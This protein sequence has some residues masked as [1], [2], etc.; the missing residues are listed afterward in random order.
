MCGICGF[1]GLEDRALLRNMNDA[2][3]HRGPDDS[4]Y[5]VDKAVG[6]GHRRLSIIDL[7]TGH[8]PLSNED[9]TIWVVFNGEIYNYKEL[10]AELSA[11]HRFAT[12]SDTEVIVHL[13]EDDPDGFV[14]RLDGMFALAIYDLERGRLTLARDPF[15]KKPLYYCQEQR[16]FFFAS[17]IKAL[18]AAGIVKEVDLDM[19]A[20]FLGYQYTRGTS[21]MF[22]SVRKLPPSHMMVVEGGKVELRKYWDVHGGTVAITEVKATEQVLSHLQASVRKRMIADV[23]IGAYLSGGIDSSAVVA[24]SRPLADYTFHTFALGFPTVSELPFARMV[25][26]HTGTEHHEIMVDEG[27]VLSAI[28]K[29][30]YHHDEPVG[31]AAILN[32]YFLSREACKWVK[33]VLAGEGGDELFAGY[34][35]YSRCLQMHRLRSRRAVG[36]LAYR[37]RPPVPGAGRPAPGPDGEGALHAGG[38]GPGPPPLHLHP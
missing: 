13:Y 1:I 20:C 11:R 29:V 38:G 7:N 27:M 3:Q 32:N 9:G 6:L 35:N 2:L 26:E 34:D 37:C 24:L 5:F 36:G 17:E 10:R 15:G 22:R 31:D 18:L 28:E 23:P 4:G 25:A 16:G 14:E 19:V 30:S 8:Q 21:T 33:V 12:S